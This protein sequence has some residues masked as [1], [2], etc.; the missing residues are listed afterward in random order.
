MAQLGDDGHAGE[1]RNQGPKG[2]KQGLTIYGA[3]RGATALSITP[4]KLGAASVGSALNATLSASGGNAPYT[5]TV[6][7][8]PPGVE[9]DGAKLEGTPTA[10][11]T[12]VVT[13]LVTDSSKATRA[14]SHTY[15]LKV[16]AG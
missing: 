2:A 6:F 12:F 10:A 4:A 7:G 16:R 13:V 9:S 3:S 14:G 15:K 11:G 1:T 5:W 8:L